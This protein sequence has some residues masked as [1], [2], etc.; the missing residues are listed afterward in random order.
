LYGRI[1]HRLH[2]LG[3]CDIADVSDGLAACGIDLADDGVSF[4]AIAARID[5]DGG[6]AVS[7]RERD[8]AADIAS[9]AGND[10]D[11]AR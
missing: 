7:E 4:R 2:R 5:H 6:T 3:V 8:G 11:F 9:G 1:G 10:G